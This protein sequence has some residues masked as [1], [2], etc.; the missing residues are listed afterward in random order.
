MDAAIVTGAGRGLGR[1]T[2]R[3]L[4][5]EGYGVVVNDVDGATAEETAADVR[6]EGGEAI[7]VEADV[8]AD[9]AAEQLVDAAVSEFDRLA[10]LVNNAAFQTHA[11][12]LELP[13]ED[14]ERVRSVALDAV[15][16]LTRAAGREFRDQ[17]DG[18]DVVNVT[19]IHDTVPRT[20]EVHYDAAKAGAWMLSKEFALE[21]AEHDVAVNCVAPGAVATPMNAELQDDP[22]AM[23]EHR[24]AIPAGRL[25][26]PEEVADAVAWLVDAGYVTGTRVEVDGGLSLVW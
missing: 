12:A 22:E 23:A 4:A 7:A 6:D 3:R 1:A 19:S 10:V 21:L 17:G 16:R 15:F 25:G 24:E 20:G 14:W 8:A 26:E 11:A 5:E 9:G 2:A 13:D 18:G